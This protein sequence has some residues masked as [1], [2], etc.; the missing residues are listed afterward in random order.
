[1]ASE[2]GAGS[3]TDRFVLGAA[4]VAVLAPVLTLVSPYLGASPTAFRG[5]VVA[6]SLVAIVFAV[7]HLRRVRATGG[8]RLAPA[9]IVA[10][11]G[12]WYVLAP[13]LY[14]TDEIAF[15]P[16]AGVHFGGL[17]LAAFGA[18]SAIEALDRSLGREADGR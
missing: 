4:V 2:H 15:A 17:L 12:L 16:T 11:F 18:Y 10:V 6:T 14:G 3:G 13:I 9:T 5:S 8:P 1:M 7:Q